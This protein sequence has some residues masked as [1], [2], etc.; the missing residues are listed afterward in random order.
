MNPYQ[1]GVAAEAFAAGLFAQA[2]C[3]VSIQYGAN[4]PEYDLLVTR[5]K[6]YRKVSVKG[7]QDGGWA[8]AVS[9]K[10][11]DR[12][13]HDA[14]ELWHQSH[15]D[16]RLLYCFVQFN[17]IE[18]GQLPRVY[19]ATARDAAR[20]MTSSRGGHGFLAVRENYRW[21]RGVGGGTVDQI[22]PE[23]HMTLQRILKFWR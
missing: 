22:P 4:Q 2:G 13:Y 16:P 7:S 17:N 11:P 10:N 23:W 15:R 19:I 18:F 6:T 3:D 14:I 1:V 20:F 9:Y 12:S 21:S 8:L 5:G